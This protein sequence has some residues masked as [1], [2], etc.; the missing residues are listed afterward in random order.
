MPTLPVPLIRGDKASS[1]TDYRDNL[2][3]NYYVV[4]RDILGAKGYLIATPGLTAFGTGAGVDRGGT[5]NERF[6]AHYRISG[7]SFCSVS[8]GG[9]VTDLGAIPGA[10]QATLKNLYSF[11]TQG[12]IA[13]GRFFL[14]DGSSLN[15]VTDSDLGNPIDGVWIDGLYFFT[16]GEYLY[17]TDL[18]PEE[19]ITPIDFESSINPLKFKTAEF[20]PDPSLG[21]DKTQDDKVLVFGRYS[22]EYFINVADENFQFQ[23]VN[24][25]S[26]KIGIV[27]THAKTEAGGLHYICGGRRDESLGIH[28]I[29]VGSAAKVST[30]EIDQILEQ[31]SEP[32]LSDM[33][34][35]TRAEKGVTFIIVHLPGE[36]LL[37]NVNMAKSLGVEYAWTL[38][39]TNIS[40]TA[41]YRAINGVFDARIGKWVYGDKRDSRIGILDDSVFTHYGEIQEGVL[42]SPFLKLKYMSIDEIEIET[43]PGFA[44]ASDDPIDPVLRF[45]DSNL[46]LDGDNLTLDGDNLTL[47]AYL[48]V[49]PE[50]TDTNDAKVFF[51]ATYNG[52]TYGVEISAQYGEQGD[53][54]QKFILRQIGYVENWIGFKLRCATKSRTAFALMAVTYA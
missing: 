10:G 27:A 53:Y 39:K 42:Y 18:I 7:E 41:I 36:T 54:N 28:A 16:D 51:S 8:S 19:S 44:V 5:Y 24:T 50:H 43:I 49:E 22:L 9:V 11:N 35:E 1:K 3:V 29:S 4:K 47:G 37:F 23:R 48:F 33:R 31:Y 15:E 46:T 21:V 32:E 13:D 12:I 20:M 14:Y 40:G 2:P 30:R 38:L 17:H 34:M 6:L 26:Q 45:I 52:V 25:R